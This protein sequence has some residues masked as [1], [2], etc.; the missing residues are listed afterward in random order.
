MKQE[1][2]LQE[3]VRW[4][5][6]VFREL[7]ER[8][9]PWVERVEGLRKTKQEKLRWKDG[10]LGGVSW[11][12]SRCPQGHAHSIFWELHVPISG[13]YRFQGL[14]FNINI[15]V[16]FQLFLWQQSNFIK[17]FADLLCLIYHLHQ[18]ISPFSIE[19]IRMELRPQYVS[20]MMHCLLEP[21]KYFN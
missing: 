8:T 12:M 19:F 1:R 21:E 9:L 11:E 3:P 10:V 4:K 13:N 16:N 5:Q 15:C 17:R 7:P 2:S 14:L 6:G 18:L 20:I